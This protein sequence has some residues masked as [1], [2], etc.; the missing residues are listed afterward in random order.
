MKV[1]IAIPAY[2]EEKSIVNVIKEIDEVCPEYDYIVINDGSLDNT[3]KVCKE[4]GCPI[5]DLPINLGLSG[6]FGCAMKY[7]W[8]K[9]Y[10]AIIQIDGDGQHNPAYISNMVQMMID[11]KCDVVIG[12]RYCENRPSLNSLRGI[13]GRLITGLIKIKTHKKVN[14]PTSGMRLYN[15]NVIEQFVNHDFMEPE[16]HTLALLLKNGYKLNEIPVEMRTRD[17]GESYLQGLKVAKYMS[18]VCIS[19]L[20]V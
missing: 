14:D 4:K 3:S 6:A 13:G 18:R 16:P 20:L 7:A 15:R 1:L 12:S 10:D 8:E 5:L 2:N 17:Q 19:I 9:E 11:N